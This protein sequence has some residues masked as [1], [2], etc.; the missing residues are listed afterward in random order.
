MSKKILK[1]TYVFY[2]FYLIIVLLG[3]NPAIGT[4]WYPR[5]AANSKSS[6][7][8][9]TLQVAGIPV[10]QE[11]PALDFSEA[12]TYFVSVPNDI[13]EITDELITGTFFF[14]QKKAEK[15]TG[16]R[17]EVE[18]ES[19]PL[20]TGQAVP[21]AI[22]IIPSSN[23]SYTEVRKTI[24]VTRSKEL[25]PYLEGLKVFGKP[26]AVPAGEEFAS[27]ENYTVTVP[28]EHETLTQND[29]T[30]TLFK[31]NTKKETLTPDI[32]LI[33]SGGM[34]DLP[35][36]VAIPVA[37]KIK[38]GTPYAD[39][40]RFITVTRENSATNADVKY[41]KVKEVKIHGETV[42]S[43]NGSDSLAEA[44]IYRVELPADK[45]AVKVSDISVAVT[46]D[47]GSSLEST[48]SFIG[49]DEV[50]LEHGKPAYLRL[51]VSPKDST[52]YGSLTKL[53]IITRKAEG[54]Q[55][56]SN[57]GAGTAVRKDAF[58]AE[59]KVK[60]KRANGEQSEQPV[61]QA[62][63][64]YTAEVSYQTAY[65]TASD[66]I[67]SVFT[68][69]TKQT[70]IAEP[71][72][73]FL[74]NVSQLNLEPGKPAAVFIKIQP[75]EAFKDIVVP[76]VIT[77][78]MPAEGETLIVHRAHLTALTVHGINVQPNQTGADF[79]ESGVY[80]VQVP[81]EKQTVRAQD[82]IPS[83][84]DEK[85]EHAI[86]GTV[87][88]NGTDVTV[89]TAGAVTN[90]Y[91][92]IAPANHDPMQ[93]LLRVKRLNNG[94]T[95]QED[96][97]GGG[98]GSAEEDLN[99]TYTPEILPPGIAFDPKKP[100][101]NPKD[102]GNHAKWIKKIVSGDI[103]PFDYYQ[104]DANGFDASKFDDWVVY[105]SAFEAEGTNVASYTFKGG[106]WLPDG[107]GEKYN[108]PDFGSGLKH[109]G[110]VWF[111][112]Y[113]S[114]PNRW[115]GTVP[116]MYDA[117]KEKRFYF[118]RFSASGGVSVD[119]SMF[120]VDTH[121]K[122]LFYYSDPGRFDSVFGN[123]V[124]RDWVDYAAPSSGSHQH[125]AEPFY[126]SDPVGYVEADGKVVM[127]KWIRENITANKYA[128]QKNSNYTE[129]AERKPHKPGYSPYR[130]NVK[131]KS[132]VKWV[133]NPDYTVAPVSFNKEPR[134]QT[135][136]QGTTGW[137]L[138]T[139]P[140]PAPE[141]EK[142][143]YQWYRNT[144]ESSEGGTPITSGGTDSSYMLPSDTTGD[145][146]YYC[147]VTNTN[148]ANGKTAGKT[149]QA[150]KVTVKPNTAV[151]KFN[152]DTAYGSLTASVDG[153]PINSGKQLK[154]GTKVVFIAQAKEGYR[155][156][157]WKGVEREDGK[158]TA[159]LL[160]KEDADVSVTF[161]RQD[162][163]V[164]FFCDPAQGV[165]R[166][167]VDGKSIQSGAKVEL[168][169]TITF[170]AE[171]YP[172]YRVKSW[173]GAAPNT[174]NIR[175]ASLTLTKAVEVQVVFE[176]KPVIAIT[177]EKFSIHF[178]CE[179]S[180]GTVSAKVE[181]AGTLPE[182]DLTDGEKVQKGRKITFTCTPSEDYELIGWKGAD[183]VPD[184]SSAVL[185]VEKETRVEPLFKKKAFPIKFSCDS[186]RGEI[187]A[188]IKDE[189]TTVE[190]GDL[191]E[192]GK[193][194]VF[195]A[196]AKEDCRVAGWSG[197][198]DN[199]AAASKEIVVT[200]TMNVSV[201]FKKSFA[202]QFACET[203]KGSITGKV[204]GGNPIISGQKLEE[205]TQITFT[206]QAGDD[207]LIDKWYGLDAAA[208][209]AEAS[210]TV[211]ENTKPV[212]LT[213]KKKT[214]T[215]SFSGADAN[216]TVTATVNGKPINSGDSVEKGS[217]VLFTAEAKT[218]YEAGSWSGA[219]GITVYPGKTQASLVV[220]SA[221]TVTASFVKQPDRV[222][223]V[224]NYNETM[225]SVTAI[226]NG[227][228]VE[229]DGKVL[230]NS[231]VTF[232]VQPKEGYQLT[233]WEGLPT[234]AVVSENK[235]TV[236]V[237]ASVDLNLVVKMEKI[238][239][240]RKLTI[241]A[242]KIVNKD[243]GGRDYIVSFINGDAVQFAYFIYNFRARIFENTA[244]KGS[245]TSLWSKLNGRDL[246]GWEQ[247]NLA[248]WLYTKG[249]GPY[250]MIS[251]EG[252]EQS[253]V[254]DFTVSPNQQYFQLDTK[255]V[256]YDRY[257]YGRFTN[258]QF[259]S[260]YEQSIMDFEYHKS[261]DEWVYR[262]AEYNIPNVTITLPENFVLKRG[263]AKEFTIEY[264]VDNSGNKAV[265]T[266]EVTY[267]LKWE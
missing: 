154:K 37:V 13:S 185:T 200:D 43:L 72:V 62:V 252:A 156:G 171:A 73:T 61:T 83:L 132:A 97:P 179:A 174:E 25:M 184:T 173:I 6:P 242:K 236:E 232:L 136:V 129:V 119:N 217:V 197:L 186:S 159:V 248:E 27:A 115:K 4:P 54:A 126:M 69:G 55:N 137:F 167:S 120:C 116:P 33:I 152:C 256:K 134:S 178:S 78:K 143:S 244:E 180:Y 261:D 234:D 230:K 133:L 76:L 19:V 168:D 104:A 233:D 131:G 1:T 175:S 86:S 226:C 109:M 53:I 146:Y 20:L 204:D 198:S 158:K 222:T 238:P 35:A 250:V 160:V 22:K 253:I 259:I 213:F 103:D 29:I 114:R 216:G 196:T 68:D 9:G 206:A 147:T 113:D 221:T 39:L 181:K 262:K 112:R 144:S 14:S 102:A 101:T 40:E 41:P 135:F 170:T 241:T 141:G 188:R 12:E 212:W 165:L 44:P 264:Y 87:T 254:K 145:F 235:L 47:S 209:S 125:F 255:L 63:S 93:K 191:V 155:P 108:G 105:I 7:Y 201:T 246:A 51:K 46:D 124:P 70:Q 36:G 199:S 194:V 190:S 110:N 18:G 30:V 2:I 182:K 224:F 123:A 142:L 231:S 85:K 57:G 192:K 243:L 263:Q 239:D 56:P 150:V 187:I 15:I 80:T 84:L 249:N 17:I 77:R 107:T 211:N 172:E 66:F 260:K 21:V 219:D 183:A 71:K 50:L 91:I 100:A 45:A 214:V 164:D 265:G 95:E 203:A 42:Q 117:E 208:G 267:T 151:V 96:T 65:L 163:T 26:A 189:G 48:V 266:V 202:V 67:P 247:V 218:G 227:K 31:D 237:K 75:S 257:H 16:I 195:T 23:L 111:Y 157:T 207:Y 122:F 52:I 98:S 251:D 92:T 240:T 223:V 94:S 10:K 127:Y 88:L 166:A 59:L 220:D 89:L 32:K 162:V 258:T 130:H 176:K 210:I 140:Y 79:S 60:E 74:N 229:S 225:G 148:T 169:K 64:G 81:Y 99:N 118:Y 82:I 161:K 49:T 24:K 139:V 215:V 3:C 149:T 177:D 153:Q 11:N 106:T 90:I 34:L 38:S 138:Q 5:A 58:F 228:T 205:G 8:I 28:N 121:S 245:F 128:A 193:T